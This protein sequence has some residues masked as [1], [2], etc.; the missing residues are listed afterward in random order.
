MRGLAIALGAATASLVA[1][2]D[3]KTDLRVA[4]ASSL[5]EPVERYA[6][7]FQRARVRLSFGSSD[8]LAA[9]VRSG[10]PIDVLLVADPALL[11]DLGPLLVHDASFAA[12]RL[13]V[14][15]RA[16]AT[17][18]A[19]Y[20]DLTRAGVTIGAGSRRAPIGRYTRRFLARLEPAERARIVRNIRTEEPDVAGVAGKLLAGAVDAGFVYA[21]D[22][23]TSQGKLRA[24]ELPAD[25]A[26]A[27]EYA[28]GVPERSPQRLVAAE[29]ARGL[30]EGPGADALRAAGF[31]VP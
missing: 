25:L 4:A 15:T 3:A 8:E 28:A 1:C 31:T 17:S 9:Q 21:S 16:Q 10:A 6:Q 13:V 11:D 12:N 22:V 2:G 18:I 29:F 5:R 7:T 23:A 27:P 19:T 20:A 30:A 26:P 14:A 24:I